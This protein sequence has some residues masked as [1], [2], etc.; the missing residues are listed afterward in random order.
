MEG[1]PSVQR[2]HRVIGVVSPLGRRVPRRSS[3]AV[4][5][6]LYKTFAHRGHYGA[7][8][9]GHVSDS[10]VE[11]RMKKDCMLCGKWV[12]FIPNDV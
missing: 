6:A 7:S 3:A 8:L 4:S 9:P 10:P 1:S 12:Q 11:T 2:S 5:A